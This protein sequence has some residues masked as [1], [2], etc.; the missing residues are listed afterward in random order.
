MKPVRAQTPP[1]RRRNRTLLPSL[2][3]PDE[4]Q[5]SGRGVTRSCGAGYTGSNIAM[6]VHHEG[7]SGT[8][9]AGYAMV[10]NADVPRTYRSS[11]HGG[12]GCAVGSGESMVSQ[13]W[14]GP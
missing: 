2:T 7:C 4:T 1:P 13:S 11:V 14:D 5:V 6:S 12:F 9:K 3:G 8:T 10:I